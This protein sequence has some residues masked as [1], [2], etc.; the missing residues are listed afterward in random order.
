MNK[1]RLLF[2]APLMPDDGGNGLA[3]RSGSFLSAFARDFEVDLL[4]APIAGGLKPTEFA[5]AGSR[6][7][8]V[9]PM[10]SIVD[11]HASLIM[12]MI[13]PVAQAEAWARYPRPSLCWYNPASAWRALSER[14]DPFS[15]DLIH[16]QR[17][18][19]APLIGPLLRHENRPPVILDLDDDEVE[20][21]ERLAALHRLRGEAPQARI[22]EDDARKFGALA[23]HFFPLFDRVLVCSERD[24]TRLSRLYPGSD[25]ARMPNAAPPHAPVAAREVKTTDLILVGNLSYV[26]NTDAAEWLVR[27]V[28]PHMVGV[29]AMLVGR[30]APA[31]DALGAENRHVTVTDRVPDPAPYY[32][33]ARIAVAPLRTGGGTRIKILEAFAH[34]VPVVSTRQGAEGLDLDNEVHLLLADEPEDFAAQCRR[35]L[36]DAALAQKLADN[37][38]DWLGRNATPEIVS[39]DIRHMAAMLRRPVPDGRD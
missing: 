4:V 6:R 17:L 24:R 23:A 22:A 21:Y 33:D 15:Y 31:I 37:A 9:M 8:D 11:A 34:G 32:A 3:L 20:F 19:C 14:V 38:A 16:V 2:I 7:L 5:L 27:K 1:P 29:T 26:P 18:S 28:L 35:L 10:N 30:S 13:D 36:D 39:G 25:F 12:R